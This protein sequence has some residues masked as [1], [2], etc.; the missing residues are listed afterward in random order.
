MSASAWITKVRAAA[1]I[2][3]GS[4]TF[5]GPVLAG[6]GLSH[7]CN[8]RCIH[9]YFFS[10]L[11]ETPNVRPVRRRRVNPA[12]PEVDPN[13][14][15]GLEMD[16][17]RAR[18]LIDELLRMGTRRFQ[19]AGNGEVFL[20]PQALELMRRVKEGGGFCFTNTNG[21]LIEP[22]VADELI[23]MGFDELRVTVM[24][25]SSEGYVRTH[26]GVRASM[27]DELRENLKYLAAQKRRLGRRTPQVTLVFIVVK[28]NHAELLQFARLAEE[29]GA[30]R[31]LVRPVDDVGD[32]GLMGVVPSDDEAAVVRRQ[33][34]EARSLLEK[35]GIRHNIPHFLGAF[36]RKLDT[37]RVYQTIP[38]VYA[39]L[40]TMIEADGTVYPCCRCY[41]PMGNV[42]DAGFRA[43]WEGEAYRE[44]RRKTLS[45]PKRSDPIQGCTC[46]QCVHY[47]ANIRAYRTLHP[48]AQGRLR[49]LAV[50]GDGCGE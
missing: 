34:E 30:V 39:W 18:E 25:G 17:V 19:L 50:C 11:V 6:I 4:R 22:R 8:L 7:R 27:F 29:V 44:H 20:H 47:E 21:T 41:D 23:G 10:P 15:L 33:I 13:L 3:S 43:V 9:C 5:G 45:L 24:A 31:V 37:T 1:G 36:Q 32:A 35:A 12:A 28:Q 2:L 16:P 38:C 49:G 40:S 48:W 14:S 26:P 42:F 46:H